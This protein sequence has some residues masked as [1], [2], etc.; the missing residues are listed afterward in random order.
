MNIG[1]ILETHLGGASA[2]LGK[3]VSNLLSKMQ[4]EGHSNKI[5]A[6]LIDIYDDENH[7]KIINKMNDDDIFDLAYNIPEDKRTL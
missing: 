7:K 6:K 4:L 5:K 2:S 3:Q 1:Q